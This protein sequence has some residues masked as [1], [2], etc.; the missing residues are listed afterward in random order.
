[1][2]KVKGKV[3]GLGLGPKCHVPSFRPDY[4]TCTRTY[5]YTYYLHLDL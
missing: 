1:M 3:K 2:S 4:C 5:T